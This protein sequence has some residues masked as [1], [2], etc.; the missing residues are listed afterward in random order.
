MAPGE[1]RGQSSLNGV[2]KSISRENKTELDVQVLSRFCHSY[3]K[4]EPQ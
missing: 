1:K 2:M 4:W 3:S